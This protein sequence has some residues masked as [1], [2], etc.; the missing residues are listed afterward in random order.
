MSKK[1]KVLK[2]M[3]FEPNFSVFDWRTTLMIFLNVRI[4]CNVQTS[5]CLANTTFL[6][7]LFYEICNGGLDFNYFHWSTAI[8]F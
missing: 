5:G 3:F 6:L 1:F 2:E 8:V 4:F 7:F